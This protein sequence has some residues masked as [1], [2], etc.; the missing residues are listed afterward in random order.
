[1]LYLYTYLPINFSYRFNRKS[2]VTK[3]LLAEQVFKKI[4]LSRTNYLVFKVD[5][6]LKSHVKI[7]DRL[8]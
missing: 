2:V 7:G 8:S 5:F 1:M 4:I 6:F 3:A